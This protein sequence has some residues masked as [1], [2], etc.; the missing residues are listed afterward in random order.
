MFGK[1]DEIIFVG[2]AMFYITFLKK[3]LKLFKSK[4]LHHY[5]QANLTLLLNNIT[6]SL[7]YFLKHVQTRSKDD[8]NH[9][10]SNHLCSKAW[11]CND[12]IKL[13]RHCFQTSLNLL[14]NDNTKLFHHFLK[15]VQIWLKD[16]A[17]TWAALRRRPCG[18]PAAAC[19]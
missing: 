18:G 5:L 11:Q 2:C 4:V 10:S 1:S 19:Q 13:L 7:F 14:W 12:K 17:F 3:C 16:D 15:H 8:A 9:L 6:K